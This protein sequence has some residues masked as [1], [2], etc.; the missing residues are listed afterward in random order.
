MRVSEKIP[1]S[2]NITSQKIIYGL[3]PIII[4]A[5]IRSAGGAAVPPLFEA[6]FFI[7]RVS[8]VQW[9]SAPPV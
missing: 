1:S 7:N 6:V 9:L 3:A 5:G 8:L 2:A 4:G